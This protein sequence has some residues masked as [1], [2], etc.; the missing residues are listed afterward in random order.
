[1]LNFSSA[2]VIFVAILQCANAAGSSKFARM[3]NDKGGIVDTSA[4]GEDLSE[5]KKELRELRQNVELMR[6]NLDRNTSQP[7]DVAQ[8]AE[9]HKLTPSDFHGKIPQ[10]LSQKVD[11]S[12]QLDIIGG[13]APDHTP[14]LKPGSA[15]PGTDRAERI[16]PLPDLSARMWPPRQSGKVEEQNGTLSDFP[17]ALPRY[18]RAIGESLQRPDIVEVQPEIRVTELPKSGLDAPPLPEVAAQVAKTPDA[19]SMSPPQHHDDTSGPNMEA[20]IAEIKLMIK[21]LETAI[22]KSSTASR[23][24]DTSKTTESDEKGTAATAV[25]SE[26]IDQNFASIT[27]FQDKVSNKVDGLTMS[28]FHAT[29]NVDC[30]EA[31]LRS[32]IK[33]WPNKKIAESLL[34]KCS[35]LQETSSLLN[36]DMQHVVVLLGIISII[37]DTHNGVFEDL[38]KMP[39]N[40]PLSG[41]QMQKTIGDKL[42]VLEKI[43][44]ECKKLTYDIVSIIGKSSFDGKPNIPSYGAF[45]CLDVVKKLLQENS[46]KAKSHCKEFSRNF[47]DL[48]RLSM[49]LIKDLQVAEK[50]DST[51]PNTIPFLNGIV[52]FL[53]NRTENAKLLFKDFT[54]NGSEILLLS[55]WL[56]K[57]IEEVLAQKKDESIFAHVSRN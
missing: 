22:M 57:Q 29:Q 46:D 24:Q 3:G 50:S 23:E 49:E 53:Q 42:D 37:A 18:Q 2:I 48:V 30:I 9:S 47:E 17:A 28:S 8:T 10:D 52:Q 6:R 27:E 13:R 45:C 51:A 33:I 54:A 35:E 40:I 1:M 20:Q 36:T 4:S 31:F 14:D 55:E 39:H 56:V 16:E 34:D 19:L 21:N 12:P 5:L 32:C 41:T 43:M 44:P 38:K 25:D 15:N 11:F 26:P 7:G